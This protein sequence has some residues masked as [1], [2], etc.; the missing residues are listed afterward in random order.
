MY[1]NIPVYAIYNPEK[2]TGNN[3]MF[4]TKDKLS[5]R[6]LVDMMEY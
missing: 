3:L 6:C 5:K 2:K 4:N 1:K